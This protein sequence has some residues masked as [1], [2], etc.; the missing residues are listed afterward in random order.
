M[1]K[2]KKLFHAAVLLCA[3]TFAC[4]LPALGHEDG[5]F[6]G[7][8]L[9][10]NDDRQITATPKDGSPLVRVQ[11]QNEAKPRI[12]SAEGSKE[13]DGVHRIGRER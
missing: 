12:Y 2:L 10:G 4:T 8:Y 6:K 11:F 5:W 9:V 7:E 13:T 1:I 3:L